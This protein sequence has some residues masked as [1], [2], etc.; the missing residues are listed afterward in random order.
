MNTKQSIQ[1][2][3]LLAAGLI[4]SLMTAGS[5]RAQSVP[6]SFAGKFTLTTPVH[7]GKSVLEPGEY[8][9]RIESMASPTVAR[10]EKEGSAFAI[11]VVSNVRDDYQGKPDAL[12]LRNKDGQ[13]VV[14]ALVLGNWKTAL[15]YGSSFRE[16]S[17]DEVR[18]NSRIAVLV[19]KQ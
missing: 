14:Q 13:L 6:T 5:G 10:I 19:A 12:Q 7:W 15:V 1:R 8:T 16:Q 2:G 4:V 18:A 9:I 17:V 3:V 11:R